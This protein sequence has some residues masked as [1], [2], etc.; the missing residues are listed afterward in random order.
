MPCATPVRSCASTATANPA[1]A[2][3]R[4]APPPPSGDWTVIDFHRA[5]VPRLRVSMREKRRGPAEPV[6]LPVWCLRWAHD[7]IDGQMVFG[8]GWRQDRSVYELLHQLLIGELSPADIIPLTVVLD[9]SRLFS[10]SHR[11]L[12]ALKM[13]QALRQNE[14]VRVP[15]LLYEACD[16]D[17][18][19]EYEDAMTTGPDLGYGTKLLLR[20]HE[21][22]AWH[23]GMPLF[24]STQDLE[25]SFLGACP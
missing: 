18:R 23:M 21:S 15:C 22:Q 16:A 10:I 5:E 11:R 12:A 7:S 17:I 4:L 9:G 3:P 2:I 6:E 14:V 1:A 24:C 8:A 19:A 20:G 25:Q 13:Y